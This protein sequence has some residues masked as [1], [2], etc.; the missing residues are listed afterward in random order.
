MSLGILGNYDD[1]VDLEDKI[2]DDDDLAEKTKRSLEAVKSSSRPSSDVES[3]KPK[4]LVSYIGGDYS[5]DDDDV[6][7]EDDSD[8]VDDSSLSSKPSVVNLGLH[9]TSSQNP[10]SVESRILTYSVFTGA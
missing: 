2:K 6:D 4:G 10:S 1:D 7:D 8:H 9:E 5:D 3:S